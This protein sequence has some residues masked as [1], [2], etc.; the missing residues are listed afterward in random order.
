MSVE[1]IREEALKRIP[2]DPKERQ[3]DLRNPE[4][5]ATYVKLRDPTDPLNWMIMGYKGTNKDE[6][7]IIAKGE[8]NPLSSCYVFPCKDL[9]SGFL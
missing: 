5:L 1:K 9:S 6:L 2:Q 3:A 4:I 7:S 8:G